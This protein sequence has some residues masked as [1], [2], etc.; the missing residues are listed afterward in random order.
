[1]SER[2]WDLSEERREGALIVRARGRFDAAAGDAVDALCGEGACVLS[3]A[4]VDYL[5]SSGVAALVKLVAT[6]GVRLASPA[7]CVRDVLG[8][9]GIERIITIHPDEAQALADAGA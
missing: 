4:A 7:P 3:L 5:S 1:M 6:R 2:P 9:A 8:L